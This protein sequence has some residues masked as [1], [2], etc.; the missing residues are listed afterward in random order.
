M[1][2]IRSCRYC[3]QSFDIEKEPY[4][5]VVVGTK[6]TT[7]RYGH[8][9]CYEKAYNDPTHKEYKIKRRVWDP[10]KTAICFWCHKAI[11]KDEENV[12]PMPQLSNRWIHKECGKVHPS[13]DLENLMIY[14]IQLYKIKEDYIPPGHMKQLN[15][16]EQEYG[17]TYSGMLKA[18]KYWYE[19]KKHPIDTTKGLG[20]IPYIYKEAK[21]YYYALWLA[22][23]ENEKKNIQDYIPKD[24]E[25]NIKIPKRNITKRQLFNFL[26][27]DNINGSQ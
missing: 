12:I 19:I 10:H 23:Q 24:I 2:T 14:L 5:Q 21:E 16:Y 3:K 25:V 8:G 13:N 22:Q 6:G 7:F 4:V 27:E 15:Q 9:S 26:D 18:L 11:E 17:M 20:I 1:A